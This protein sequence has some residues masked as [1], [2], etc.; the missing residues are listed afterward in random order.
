MPPPEL[1]ETLV[2]RLAQL[3]SRLDGGDESVDSPLLDEFN[4]LA[5][6]EIPFAEFQGIYGAEEHI[7]YVR[8]IL[9]AKATK[10]DPELTRSGLIEML[11]KVL[12]DPCNNAYLEYVFTTVEKTFGDSEVS[13]L[14]FW[15]GSYFGDGDDQR[16][17]TAEE[18]ADAV[19]DRYVRRK[20]RE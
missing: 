18:M 4:T 5:G 15:P 16:E 8:R 3:A 6:T 19:L 2:Q 10:A 17:L 14:V 1:D 20:S 13:D 11:A 12:A 9:T 7:E